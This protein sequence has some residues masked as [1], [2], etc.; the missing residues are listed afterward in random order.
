MFKKLLVFL[1]VNTSENL[2]G[3]DY[4]R[5]EL[6]MT[7]ESV[8]E[9]TLRDQQKT[10]TYCNCKLDN[11][12]DVDRHVQACMQACKIKSFKKLILDWMEEHQKKLP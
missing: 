10:C 4:K 9:S 3:I 12:G 2:F 5:H 11:W 7:I 1:L 6:P 8:C